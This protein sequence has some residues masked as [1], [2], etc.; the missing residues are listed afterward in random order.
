MF[1]DD[2][3]VIQIP[4]YPY[5]C[6]LFDKKGDDDNSDGINFYVVVDDMLLDQHQNGLEGLVLVVLLVTGLVLALLVGQG[7]YDLMETVGGDH[8]VL[9]TT[10]SSIIF[11]IIII[12]ILLLLLMFHHGHS[13]GLWWSMVL[14]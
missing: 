5:N 2:I 9:V 3:V 8:T 7:G 6:Q 10:N 13:C 4:K 11:M 14:V 1:V 12:I